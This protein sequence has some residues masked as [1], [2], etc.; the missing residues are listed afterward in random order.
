MCSSRPSPPAKYVSHRRSTQ[1]RGSSTERRYCSHEVAQSL[2]LISSSSKWL[3]LKEKHE[4]RY[5]H[6]YIYI[7]SL[8]SFTPLRSPFSRD[9][10]SS[11][12]IHFRLHRSEI[13]HKS[14]RP[15]L[16]AVYSKVLICN[17][18]SIQI[19]HLNNPSVQQ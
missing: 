2:E 18:I 7:Y 8:P 1:S 16:N 15:V 10:S 9:P 14:S 5:E 11:Y 19:N 6:L 4:V 3:Y 17:M 13:H 12:H